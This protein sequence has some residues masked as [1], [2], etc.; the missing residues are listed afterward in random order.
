MRISRTKGGALLLTAAL[1][2]GCTGTTGDT[3]ASPTDSGGDTTDGATGD[4]SKY[5]VREVSDGITS[6]VVVEN[7]DGGTTLSLS[8][9]SNFE[10]LE[11]EQD[12][13]TYAFK[14]MNGN[15][16]LDV[17]EDWRNAYNDRAADLAPQLSIDQVSG[18]M[19]FSGHESAPSDGLTDAQEEYL[20][21]SY[22]RNVL[23]AGGNTVEPVVQWTNEMQAFVETLASDGEPYV[24]VNFSSDPRHDAADSYSGAG[25]GTS[26]WPSFL[27]LAATFDADNVLE[28]GKYASEEYRA[29]G[30]ANALSPQIDLASDPRWPRIAGT[31]GEDPEIAAEMAAAYVS[32]FQGTFDDAGNNAGWGQGS[33][34]TV[35]KHFPGDGAAEGGR[36][37]HTQSGKFAVMPGDNGAA[38]LQ[39]F[40]SAIE[41]GAGGMMTSYSIITDG[42]GNPY[43]GNLMGSAY[44]KDR[45]DLA[46]V[47]MNY[48]GVVVTDWG[49]TSSTEDGT[50]SFFGM[51]WGAADLTVDERHF[52]I[53]RTGHDQ[54][55]GNNNIE[56]VRAA[57][58]LWQEAFEAGE[59]DIDADTR[60]AESGRRILT[61]LFSVG[62]YDNPYQDLELSLQTVGNE[63]ATAA[64]QA[65][66]HQ[67]VVT[68]KSA[69][70][71][72]CSA[73]PTDYSQMKVYIP[74]SYDVGIASLFGP[75]M[76]TEGATIN[77]DVAAQYFGEV[78]TDEAELDEEGQVVS[79]TAPD[80][81]DVDLVVVGLNNP[82]NGGN[83]T[84]TGY[85]VDEDGNESWYPLS[86]QYRPYTAD[87]E[88]VRKVS[89]A[90]NPLP[91]GTQQNRSYFGGTSK[92]SNESDLDAFER[93]VAA[94][95][96]SG[97]DIPVLT[98][99]SI[100]DAMVIPAEF[101]EKSDKIVVGFSVTDATL[102]DIAL[103]LEESSGR[104]PLG[105]P[106][107]MDAVENS[108]EDL[109]KDV[110]SYT[111]SNG[112]TYEF[113]FGLSCSGAAL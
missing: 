27:G 84:D 63:A 53:I 89:I 4:D 31:F 60:W 111:D 37:S 79:Y 113:G 16:E 69:A 49:V 23:Y 107:S 10:L 72:S 35:I 12:G 24:P 99:V 87:G 73:A 18:L 9:D 90:G 33:V 100:I 104:L 8:A 85:S 76:Y 48:D 108:F 82:R 21:N 11:V 98:L 15:G 83:F 41:A 36:E 40:E 47:G 65:A 112:N 70:E 86:L 58:K 43:Y 97:R 109:E 59:L 56:P 103:G 54:F 105:M 71:I 28:F 64:G 2:A 94:V 29:M 22:L 61:N 42:E 81:T 91:D 101:E 88:H 51:G 30:L 93:A 1:L 57:Y 110:E 34:S 106:A 102:L 14:D 92:I 45:M 25:G 6:F 50:G 78:V 39:V 55:G 7:P 68:L 5:S 66:Q 96:A 20:S 80:L 13:K 67:S 32:G 77:L 3:T 46:R 62:L 75:A 74:R 26:Q 52:E 95:E 17:W 19:L 44:D 38:H